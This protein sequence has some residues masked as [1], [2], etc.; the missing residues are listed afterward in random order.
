VP[1]VQEIETQDN[2]STMTLEAPNGG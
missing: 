2:E 1:A